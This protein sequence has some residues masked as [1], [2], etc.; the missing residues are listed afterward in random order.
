MNK[1]SNSSDSSIPLQEVFQ[2]QADVLKEISETVTII[3]TCVSKLTDNYLEM[4]E[5][6]KKIE[7]KV[8][9]DMN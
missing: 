4:E 5:K 6:I 8:F 1:K 9:L 3:M 2:D 7:K